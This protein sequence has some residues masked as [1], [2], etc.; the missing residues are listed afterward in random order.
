M[1]REF[2]YLSEDRPN[3]IQHHPS[4]GK[5]TSGTSDRMREEERPLP[6]RK[7]CWPVPENVGRSGAVRWC[8][9]PH[10][11]RLSVGGPRCRSSFLDEAV[12]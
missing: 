10:W 1:T 5:W 8:E 11:T 6:V 9:P 7:T 12:I 4:H 3:I 2:L